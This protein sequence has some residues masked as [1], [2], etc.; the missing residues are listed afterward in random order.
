MAI[1]ETEANRTYRLSLTYPIGVPLVLFAIA[2]VLRIV[3]IFLLPLAEAMGEAFLHK[4]LGFLLVLGYL[5]AAGRSVQAIGL[6]GRLAGKALWIGGAG[7]VLVLLLGY[8]LQWVAS[9]A[10]GKQPALVITA[11]DT[12]TGLTGGLG[13]ALLLV[14]GN[15]VNSFMEEGLFRGINLTHFRMRLGPWRANLLQ[16]A[17]FGVWHVAWPIKHLLDGETDLAGAAS[18]AG[19][20][21]LASAISGLAWGYLYLKTNSLWAPW[22]SHM[23]NNTVLNLVHIQTVGGLDADIGVLYPVITLAYVAMLLWIKFWTARW[24]MPALRAWNA[25]SDSTTTNGETNE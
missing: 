9:S 1:R 23:I 19:I 22:L 16:A 2:V 10:A 17:I 12:R 14:A 8:A 5:W 20:I 4:A 18:E 6:H 3:D 25:P 24:G 13:F 7:T 21:V 11:I 15:V